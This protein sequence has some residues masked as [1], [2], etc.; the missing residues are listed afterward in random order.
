M[1]VTNPPTSYKGCNEKYFFI[2]CDGW[3][4]YSW[5]NGLDCAFS[6]PKLWGKPHRSSEPSISFSSFSFLFVDLTNLLI[7]LSLVLSEL[8]LDKEQL[9]RVS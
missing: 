8:K 4:S 6:V 1:L 2:I 9:F 7:S 3:E 5:E